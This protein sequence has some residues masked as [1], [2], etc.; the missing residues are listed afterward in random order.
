MLT[1][2]PLHTTSVAL[3]T[4]RRH[5]HDQL[6][7]SDTSLVGVHE[8]A[9]EPGLFQ[10]CSLELNLHRIIRDVAVQVRLFSWRRQRPCRPSNWTNRLCAWTCSSSYCEIIVG[11]LKSSK[12][13]SSRQCFLLERKIQQ[14]SSKSPSIR[15]FCRGIGRT[16]VAVQSPECSTRVHT[17]KNL[18]YNV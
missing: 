2:V 6:T 5:N 4:L 16:K 9:S 15:T 3:G 11:R 10:R 1:W 17:K 7:S 13:V 18:A 8:V 12:H 14:S